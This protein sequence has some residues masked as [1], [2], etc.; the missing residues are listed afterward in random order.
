M[1]ANGDCATYLFPGKKTDT[2]KP[3]KLSGPNTNPLYTE[4]L[5]AIDHDG[6]SGYVITPHGIAALKAL[7]A[8][9]A[10]EA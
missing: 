7:D 9:K 3:I 4:G 1:D 6:I 8:G 10:G 5:I 2:R